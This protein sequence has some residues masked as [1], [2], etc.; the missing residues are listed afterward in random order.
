MH[1]RADGRTQ[2][3]AQLVVESGEELINAQPALFAEIDEDQ[4]RSTVSVSP[5]KARGNSSRS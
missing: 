3:D 4:W 1:I 5:K 2:S